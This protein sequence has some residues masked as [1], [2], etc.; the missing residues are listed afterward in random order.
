MCDKCGCTKPD[1]KKDDPKQC[2]PED[3]KE[4]HP[5]SQGHPCEVKKEC[6]EEAPQAPE[7]Q[8]CE[9]E[10]CEEKKEGE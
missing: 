1:E 6:K 4:C 8:P 5:E 7:C 3:I 10:P 9:K 2:T